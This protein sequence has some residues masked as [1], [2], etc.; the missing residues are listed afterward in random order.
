[1]SF[2]QWG[3]DI[4]PEW[5]LGF[6]GKAWDVVFGG[7]EDEIKDATKDG[8]KARFVQTAPDDALPY[9]GDER[10]LARGRTESLI[11]YRARLQTAWELHKLGGT[12]NG[13]E[14]SLF[15]IWPG[16]LDEDFTSAIAVNDGWHFDEGSW[17]RY[18]ILLQDSG[19]TQETWGS[20]GAWDYLGVWGLA[21]TT[22]EDIQA[23]RRNAWWWTS[24][25][26]L[27]VLLTVVFSGEVWDPTELWPDG[28]WGAATACHIRLGSYWGL[29][30]HDFGDGVVGT[31]GLWGDYNGAPADT[32]G[33]K[34]AGVI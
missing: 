31:E 8:V 33:V 14:R 13:V 4:K 7:F 22:P 12:A 20:D 23:A 10:V 25:G 15:P 6:W 34:P 17:S 24:K 28:T 18:W 9:I 21:N 19:L 2:E 26:T 29:E 11:E 16:L 1:V 5:L 30:S 3:Q 27:P 32:W